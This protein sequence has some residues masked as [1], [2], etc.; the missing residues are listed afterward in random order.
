MSK[1]HWHLCSE[2]WQTIRDQC[3]SNAESCPL[4]FI[5]IFDIA[6]SV[7]LEEGIWQW[8]WSRLIDIKAHQT[9]EGD[10]PL[11]ATC[12][13]A[14]KLELDVAT[15]GW[16]SHSTHFRSFRRR[17]GDCGISKDYSR[18]IAPQCVRCWVVC[19]RP[20]LTTVVC[21]CINW[22]APCPYVLDARLGLGLWVSLEHAFTCALTTNQAE[23]RSGTTHLLDRWEHER[24]TAWW[25]HAQEGGPSVI[26]KAGIHY[27]LR[28]L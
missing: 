22:K 3:Y 5:L 20:L 4:A 17:W 15:N 11:C 13:R 19:E 12:I 21:M 1:N 23:W 10:R 16:L 24:A 25:S 18:S 2:Q 9:C 27:K 8:D 14:V 6:Y 28:R 7:V 26:P